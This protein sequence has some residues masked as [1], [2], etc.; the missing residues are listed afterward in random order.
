M[1][2]GVESPTVSNPMNK[3]SVESFYQEAKE[4]LRLTL[5]SGEKGLAKRQITS[6]D[7]NRLGMALTGFF[8]FFAADRV[9]ILGKTEVSY[10]ET[11]PAA[12]RKAVWR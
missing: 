10:L 4:R 11:L 9:Q 6:V 7:V 5:V 2:V 3:L 8:K 1:T 12:A